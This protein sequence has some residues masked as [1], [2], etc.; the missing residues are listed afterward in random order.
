MGRVFTG[1]PLRTADFITGKFIMPSAG[2]TGPAGSGFGGS[3]GAVPTDPVF[4]TAKP[5]LRLLVPPNQ[6]FTDKL[7]VGVIAMGIDGGSLANTLGMEKVILHYEGN[8][9]DLVRPSWQALLDVNGNRVLYYGWWAW[10]SHN[11]VNGTGNTYFE[12]VPRNPTMQRR[13]IGPY[14]F[15]PSAAIHDAEY[16]MAPSLSPIT[17]QRFQSTD[18]GVVKAYLDTLVTKP[19]NPRITIIEG[20]NYQWS[21]QGSPYCLAGYLTVE[22]TAPVTIT[23]PASIA[24]MR[25]RIDGIHFKGSNITLDL[26]N[27]HQVYHEGTAR[28]HWFNGIYITDS[29]GR[30]RLENKGPKLTTGPRGGGW[31]TEC[32]MTYLQDWGVN[33]IR[34]GR[35]RFGSRDIFAGSQCV[36]GL[37]IQDH[38][39]DEYREAVPAMTVRYTGAGTGTLSLAG[40]NELNNRVLTAKVAGSTVG[41]FTISNNNPLGNYDV[42]DVKAWID[43]LGAGWSATVLSDDRRASALC[44]V[45]LGIHGFTDLDV[46]TETITLSCAFDHHSDGW[47]G[48]TG[49]ITENAVFYNVRAWDIATQTINVGGQYELRSIYFVNFAFAQDQASPSTGVLLSQFSGPHKGVV[50]AHVTSANQTLSLRTDLAGS[51]KYNPDSY[52]A[53]IDC[54]WPSVTWGS[55][56][57]TDADVLISGNHT[58]SYSVHNTQPALAVNHSVG[59]DYTT[60]YADAMNGDF[61]P[62]GALL[63]NPKPSVLRFDPNRVLRG[64]NA[65]AGAWAA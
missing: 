14:E 1:R 47:Q 8:T 11:G 45:P 41:T 21:Q 18:L 46:K 15:L 29:G 39:S 31:T 23:A 35:W 37:T 57:G 12:A 20:G 58:D 60:K 36:T 61:T 4:A 65:P 63:A 40:N 24:N 51:L 30:Y 27:Y 55:G 28:S 52:C 64:A 25:T 54:A 33:L 62:A 2:F 5:C 3:Y 59:G 49:G 56:G 32:E 22:A 9:I 7:L 43:S 17:G 13:V 50:L 38:S 42:S 26:V 16:V 6:T 19:R 34:G 44:Y 53:I 48:N 10:L